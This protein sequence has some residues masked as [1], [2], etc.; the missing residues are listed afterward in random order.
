MKCRKISLL[1]A[2]SAA[3]LI[4]IQIYQMLFFERYLRTLPG[5]TSDTSFAPPHT[6]DAKQQKETLPTVNVLYALSGNHTG[7]LSELEVA[8]KSLLMNLP[9]QSNLHVHIMADKYGYN[10]LDEIFQRTEIQTWK[11]RKPVTIRTYNVQPNVEKWQREVIMALEPLGIST[12]HTFGTFF[13]LFF[14]DVIGADDDI[15]QVLYMDPDVVLMSNIES[16]FTGPTDPNIL[17]QWGESQCAGFLLLNVRKQ[18]QILSLAKGIDFG[19]LI[20]TPLIK[21]PPHDQFILKAINLTYPEKVGFIPRE[22]D[23]S[24]ADGI[25]RDKKVFV[26]KHPEIGMI[27]FNGGWESKN[28]PFFSKPPI[29]RR[30]CS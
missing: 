12:A 7:L 14:H 28:A 21:G 5:V 9:M 13:R 3:I 29:Y 1:L 15:E 27:H 10:G 18:N 26:E 20:K 19:K 11:T 8:L 22:W 25:W 4:F 23:I 24:I 16:L 30:G 2:V 6:H 17:F